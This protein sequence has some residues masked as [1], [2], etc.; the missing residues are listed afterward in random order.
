MRRSIAWGLAASALL[1]W[2]RFAPGAEG[3]APATAR[4]ATEAEAA[5]QTPDFQRHVLPLMGRVGCNTRSCH[6]SFQGQGEASA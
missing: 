2:V 4:F 1:G 6:G 3:T 5:D